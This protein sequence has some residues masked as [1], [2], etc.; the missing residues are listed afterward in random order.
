[1]HIT[2]ISLLAAQKNSYS[3][4]CYHT[5]RD[6]GVEMAFRYKRHARPSRP[7]HPKSQ[8]QR[9]V[10]IEARR[11]AASIGWTQTGDVIAAEAGLSEASQ[12]VLAT[13]HHLRSAPTINQIQSLQT[14]L[15]DLSLIHDEC[16]ILECAI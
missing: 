14:S 10:G 16:L 15:C 2:A 5:H 1:M 4:F 3:K 12:G 7:L 11:Q 13:A 9:V 6:T 8:S